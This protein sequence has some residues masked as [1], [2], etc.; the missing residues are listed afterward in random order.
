MNR[1]LFFLLVFL[2]FGYSPAMAQTPVEIQAAANENL[3]PFQSD[4]AWGPLNILVRNLGGSFKVE[5]KSESTALGWILKEESDNRTIS[6]GG[7]SPETQFQF[8]V[9]QPFQGPYRLTVYLDSDHEEV[10]ASIRLY[11]QN[12]N[13][14]ENPGVDSLN[15]YQEN[16]ERPYDSM[17]KNLYDEAAADYAKGDNLHAL[18]LLKKAEELDTV[19]PQVEAL[20]LKIQGPSEKPSNGPLDKIRE[21]LKEGKKEEALAKLEDYIDANPDD[22]EAQDL[23]DQID[24]NENNPDALKNAL[25]QAE[26]SDQAG[27]TPQA[28][29]WYK[30]VLKL[31]PQNKEALSVLIRLKTT[32]KHSV[33]NKKLQLPDADA[34]AQADQTYNLGLESYRK[35]DY[36]SA[37]RFWE[38]TLQIMPTHLQAR[39]NLDHLKIEHPELK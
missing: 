7:L 6:K 27:E 4:T 33:E 30:K 15:D 32:A 39:Q 35:D 17:V 10:P 37:K 14:G 20:I 36:A 26:K 18:E 5:V 31:D 28:V 25:A 8:G 9:N 19:Q 12:G 34:Q 29:H 24:G 3:Y 22:E 23:K 11:I 38:E 2:E 1:F 16:S 13:K 21:E